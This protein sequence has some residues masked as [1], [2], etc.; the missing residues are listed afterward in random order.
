VDSGRDVFG[1]NF[2]RLAGFV[3]YDEGGH[4]IADTVAEALSGED[5]SSV[6]DNGEIFVD[7]GANA[8][9]QN[10]DLTTAATRKTGPFG[11]GPHFAVGARRFASE[12][13]DLGA[14]VEFDN[15]QGHSLIGVRALDY[16]YRFRGPLA[17]NVFIGA[18]RYALATPAYGIY[19]GAGLQ[20]RNVLPKW[21]VGFDYRYA[22]SVARD[23]L[24]PND[25]PNIGG[26]SDSFYN[27]SLFTFSV[28][29]HF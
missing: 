17:L 27:I 12:H 8:N 28:S 14:R 24:L 23:H 13:S 26:R 3:R 29:R 16:R 5:P 10:V 19:Y 4:G 7:V 1:G 15:V 18:A 25:P 21:D 11:Y 9:R 2:S 20:W 6:I 22:D